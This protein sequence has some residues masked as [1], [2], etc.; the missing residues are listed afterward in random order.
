MHTE[1]FHI[2]SSM[3]FHEINTHV[4]AALRSRK[5]TNPAP[6]K[7]HPDTSDYHSDLYHH[8]YIICFCNLYQWDRAVCILLCLAFF[9]C[10]GG[11]VHE[12]V[13]QSVL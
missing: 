2:I 12:I 9:T 8:R 4:E 13:M 5:G 10:S 1:K 7:P 6:Q 3:N 11:F